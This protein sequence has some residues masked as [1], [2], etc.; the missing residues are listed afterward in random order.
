[1]NNINLRMVVPILEAFRKGEQR[2]LYQLYNHNRT[3]GSKSTL[4]KYLHE[5]ADKGL[6]EQKNGRLCGSLQE[7]I[8]AMTDKGR[9]A[10]HHARALL[11]TLEP[12]K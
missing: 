9:I 7:K 4:L 1:M 12:G 6:L 2:N 3:P 10:L 8:Y 11:E 5:F